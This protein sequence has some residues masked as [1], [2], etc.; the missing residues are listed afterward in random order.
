[1]PPYPSQPR[2]SMRSSATKGALDFVQ[3]FGPLTTAGWGSEGENANSVMFQAEYMREVLTAWFGKQKPSVIPSRRSPIDFR[4]PLVVN[5]YDT[6]PSIRLEAKVVCDPVTRALKWQ[7]RPN[8][9]LDALGLQLG[10]KLTG[11][12][13]LRQCEHCG[14]WFEAGQ[15]TGRRL[16]AK[17]WSD[18]HRILY[19]SL[20]RSR[21]K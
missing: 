5:R 18:E 7:L 12:A 14:D 6:G 4:R 3:R 16:D 10:Q 20:K 1:M 2:R 17:F 13:Q 9:L 21:R 8:S 11:G 19:N 15:G